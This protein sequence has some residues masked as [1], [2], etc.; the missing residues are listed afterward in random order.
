[1]GNFLQA[2]VSILISEGVGFL[3]SILSS[4]NMQ[5]IFE[6]LKQPS[7]APPAWLFAPVWII[8]YALMGLA[9]YRIWKLGTDRKDVKKALYLYVIQLF[10]N[11]LWPIIFFRFG[12]IGL[13]LLEIVILLLFI[14]LT[15]KSFLKLDKIAG[16]LMIPYV[17]WVMFAT[18]LNYSIWILNK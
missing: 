7:F 15:T 11:F 8:L 13:A 9:A 2:L 4:G 16:Y 17:L 10:L 1:M 5:Q 18:I 3:S 12:L 6:T 14:V